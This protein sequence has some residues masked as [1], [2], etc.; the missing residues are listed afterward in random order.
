MPQAMITVV[1]GQDGEAL[2][3]GPL[4]QD[5]CNTTTTA[6]ALGA[7]VAIQTPITGLTTTIFGVGTATT[8]AT[9]APLNIGISVGAS[10]TAGTTIPAAGS[11][12]AVG[13]FGQVVTHGQCRALVDAT[14]SPTVVGH[15]L[16]VGGTTAGAL[17]D[18]G[19]TTAAAGVNYGVVLEAVT[20]A[21]GTALV[22]VWFEKT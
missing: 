15:R 20:I 2:F 18:A 21:S 10:N 4:L 8:T 17:S 11:V 13:G 12:G 3:S 14:T 22:N 5:V 16:I 1:G 19:T 9:L 7:L 6:I